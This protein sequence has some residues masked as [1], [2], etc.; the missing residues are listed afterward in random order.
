MN[1]AESIISAVSLFLLFASGCAVPES[2]FPVPAANVTPVP[3]RP[4]E[5]R[6]NG[7][8]PCALVPKTDW[9]AFHIERPGKFYPTDGVGPSP[10]CEYDS[11]VGLF[12]IVLVTTEG[13]HEWDKG[14][15]RTEPARVAPVHGF[16]A[17]SLLLPGEDRGCDIIVDV[18]EGQYLEASAAIFLPDPTKVPERCEYAH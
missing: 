12:S 7:K 9:P 18:A 15:R 17:I 10:D 13:I 8:D 14:K 16:P 1:R 4:R 5:I 2:G 3:A 11:A 6:L